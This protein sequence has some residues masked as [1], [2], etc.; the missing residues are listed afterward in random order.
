[1]ATRLIHLRVSEKLYNEINEIVKEFGF[2]SVADFLRESAR[3]N[4]HDHELKRQIKKGKVLENLSARI[5]ER[6]AEE[7]E[8][9]SEGVEKEE[10]L[11]EEFDPFSR[12]GLN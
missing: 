11:E 5:E 7:P 1:M 2:Q 10:S 4:L 3:K 8:E 12:R 9:E 6:E